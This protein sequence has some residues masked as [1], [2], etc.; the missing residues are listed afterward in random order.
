MIRDGTVAD[1]ERI[2]SLTL[3]DF[4]IDFSKVQI[5]DREGPLRMR[6]MKVAVETFLSSLERS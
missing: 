2:E 1:V 4:A 5:P 6:E 3:E